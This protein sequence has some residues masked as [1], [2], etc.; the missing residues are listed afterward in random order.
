M[1][2][3]TTKDSGRGTVTPFRAPVRNDVQPT[4]PACQDRRRSADTPGIVREPPDNSVEVDISWTFQRQG[5]RLQISRQRSDEAW[6]LTV[7]GDGPARVFTFADCAQLV[8]FQTDMEALLVQTGWSL[9]AFMPDRRRYT[10]RRDFPRENNDRRRW[11][12]DVPQPR[13]TSKI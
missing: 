5:E 8:R 10:D 3:M 4:A 6:Q 1:L 7:Q 13:G 12:T 2:Y 11:W 9:A